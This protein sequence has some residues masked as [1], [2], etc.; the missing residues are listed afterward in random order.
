[1]SIESDVFKAR[2]LSMQAEIVGLS[3]MVEDSAKTVD[4]DQNRLG[5][6]SRMD[7]MQGQAMAA[8]AASRQQGHLK[9]IKYALLRIKQGSFGDCLKCAK[10]IALGRLEADPTVSYCIKCAQ[11]R[12]S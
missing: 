11:S 8:A 2:L 4:L 3:E 1:M 6:L 5:R 9:S 12:E 10:P 7:A